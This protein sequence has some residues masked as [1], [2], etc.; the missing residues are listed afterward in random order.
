[1]APII[2]SGNVAGDTETPKRQRG[3]VCNVA[4]LSLIVDDDV[5][6]R[7]RMAVA[8]RIGFKKTALRDSLEEAMTAW[9]DKE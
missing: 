9:I 7:F 5:E 6:Q 2:R 4:R 1:M 8:Q 3:S